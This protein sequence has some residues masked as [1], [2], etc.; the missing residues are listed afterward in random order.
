MPTFIVHH[1]GQFFEWSTVCDG[2]IS[3]AMSDADFRPYYRL[4]RGEDGM[5]GLDQR[6]DR[7]RA[8]GTSCIEPMSAEDL[9]DGN[10]AGPGEEELPFAEVLKLV[11]GGGADDPR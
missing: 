3:S 4:R 10:R 11:T 1:E 9:I 5:E 7:A 6:L 2:P 8:H